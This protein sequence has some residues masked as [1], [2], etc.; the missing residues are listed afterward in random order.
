MAFSI[1]W[2]AGTL[3]R[4]AGKTYCCAIKTS[5]NATEISRRAIKPLAT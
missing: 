5:C 1:G 3:I 2:F 4:S